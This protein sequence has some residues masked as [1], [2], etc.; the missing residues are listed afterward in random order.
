MMSSFVS[1]FFYSTV[2]LKILSMLLHV[3]V[4]HSFS[5]LYMTP[6]FKCH[7]YLSILL[8]LDICFPF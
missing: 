5:L 4:A 8:L 1:S 6:F 7:I 2:D 3:I